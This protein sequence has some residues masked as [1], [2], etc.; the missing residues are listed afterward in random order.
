[1]EQ[2]QTLT[3]HVYVYRTSERASVCTDKHMKGRKKEIKNATNYGELRELRKTSLRGWCTPP[4]H[5]DVTCD[6]RRN[7]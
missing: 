5:R 1:M 4:G 7:V 6:V 3:D 2:R